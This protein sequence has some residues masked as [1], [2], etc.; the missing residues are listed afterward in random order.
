LPRIVAPATWFVAKEHAGEP[1]VDLGWAEKVGRLDIVEVGGDHRTMLLPPHRALLCR[2]I[3][4][5]VL[6]ATAAALAPTS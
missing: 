4:E 3:E 5:R 1:M 6:A 2:L